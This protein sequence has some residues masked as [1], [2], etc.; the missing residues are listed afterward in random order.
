MPN[1]RSVPKP[2]SDLGGGEICIKVSPCSSK[3]IN[4]APQDAELVALSAVDEHFRQVQRGSKNVRK[5]APESSVSVISIKNCPPLC[6]K[7]FKYR[8]PVHALKGLFRASHGLRALYQGSYL[9]EHGFTTSAPLALVRKSHINVTIEEW[10]IMAATPNSKELDRYVVDCLG[11]GWPNENKQK[12]L[13]DSAQ[14]LAA[15]HEASI[16]H[17]DLKTCNI[18]VSTQ[19]SSGSINFSLLDYDD[20]KICKNGL[21][22]SMRAKNFS[23]IFLSTPAAINL[24]DRRFFL[25]QYLR[26]CKRSHID[27]DRLIRMVLAR[28][29]GKSLLYVGPDGDISEKSPLEHETYE[30]CKR[31]GCE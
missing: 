28:I 19:C 20:V 24:D 31:L 27:K 17:T 23:Q 5:N 1:C 11:K 16:F 8:G 2:S 6:V 12:F 14:F 10:L 4:L 22:L 21:R 26:S 18:M 7:H 25:N 13:R 29:K 3:I 9:F 15:V 30:Y